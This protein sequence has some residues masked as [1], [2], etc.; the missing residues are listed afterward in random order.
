MKRTISMMKRAQVAVL[1]VVVAL[2]LVGAPAALA[3]NGEPFVLGQT[4]VATA[5]SRVA[6][7]VGVDG[8]MVLIDNNNA[9]SGAT[10]LELRVEP[11]KAPMKVNSDTRVNNL[12]AD[13][14]DGQDSSAFLG[15]DQKAV[16]SELLDGQDSTDFLAA[17]LPV[18]R[19]RNQVLQIIPNATQTA[20]RWTVEDFDQVGAGRSGE[21]HSTTT[22]TS[23]LTAPRAGIY[24][25]NVKVTW[26][27]QSGVD[28]TP[29]WAGLKKNVNGDCTTGGFITNVHADDVANNTHVE[30]PTN[31]L[32]TLLALDQGEYVEVCV[33]QNSGGQHGHRFVNNNSYATMSFVSGR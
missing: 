23:R 18:V 27:T 17:T 31:H 1:A 5:I 29:R 7:A 9:G 30:G 26:S 4:N 12:N 21:M 16:D 2:V 15:A 8:P 11:G 22:N 6:G 33:Y 32:N 19:V 3:A 24:L 14:L 28:G 25:V 10:A 13:R 20:L